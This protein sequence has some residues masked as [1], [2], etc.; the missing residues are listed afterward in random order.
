VGQDEP[1][2]RWFRSYWDEEDTWFY[3]EV[4]DDG[5]VNRQVELEGPALRPIVA[6]STDDDDARCGFTA[7]APV[8]DWEGHVEEPLTLQNFEES[9]PKPGDTSRHPKPDMPA[10]GFP[11]G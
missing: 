2:T 1:V 7:E 6:A 11:A 4:S 10:A 8:T 3:F 9:G 5:W